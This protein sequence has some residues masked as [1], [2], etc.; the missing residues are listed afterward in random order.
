MARQAAASGRFSQA[1]A[2]SQSGTCRAASARWRAL[3]RPPGG[4]G[5]SGVRSTRRSSRSSAGPI[6]LDSPEASARS[7]A[8]IATE[9]SSGCAR[10]SF[11]R[12]SSS[13]GELSRRRRRPATRPAGSGPSPGPARGVDEHHQ[14]EGLVAALRPSATSDH[15]PPV[16]PGRSAD[17]SAI[18]RP[19][20]EASSSG[21]Q[22]RPGPIRGPR[23]AAWGIA[24]SRRNTREPVGG[25]LLGQGERLAVERHRIG[26]VSP[27]RRASRQLAGG[28]RP[29]T[30]W[31]SSSLVAGG[32]GFRA[33]PIATRRSVIEPALT[34]VEARS[35]GRR[36]A[37]PARIA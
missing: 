24:G 14:V 31:L 32:P 33:K 12:G 18:D 23:G 5:S 3:A 20:I 4:S 37:G 36:G 10:R 16:G 17:A 22:V 35:A 25:D 28:R 7:A 1:R 2:T 30:A 21:P 19:A 15:P 27:A 8:A 26:G 13:A 34:L 6:R 9:R 29:G 11:S